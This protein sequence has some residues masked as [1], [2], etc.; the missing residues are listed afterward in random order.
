VDISEAMPTDDAGLWIA[1]DENGLMWCLTGEPMPK[2]DSA[3]LIWMLPNDSNGFCDALPA[4]D[5]ADMPPGT[6]RRITW[7]DLAAADELAAI[8]AREAELAGWHEVMGSPQTMIE[9]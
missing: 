1:K 7:A 8:K 3:K 5:W 4:A 6:K 9:R 2:D